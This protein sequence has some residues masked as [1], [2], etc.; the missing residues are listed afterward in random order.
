M[1]FGVA[2]PNFGADSSAAEILDWAQTAE[3]LGFHSVWT[4]EHIIVGP[5]AVDPYGRVYEPLLTLGWLAGQTRRIRLGTSVILVPLHH[6]IYLAKQVATLAELTGGRFI[7]GVGMGWHQD[8]YEFMGV[9]FRGRGARADEAIRL[10]RSLWTGSQKFSGEHWSFAHAT[11]EPVPAQ[12]PEIWVGGP[13]SRAVRRARELGDTWHPT[14]TTSA[15]D[16]ARVRHE[17]PDLRIVPRTDP[18][19]AEAMLTA[20]ADG[21]I[22]NFGSRSDM[23]EFAGTHL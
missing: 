23:G 17:Y 9:E 12:Q 5:E 14:R 7:L 6:P 11:F 19:N 3:D 4:T 21:V 8:E 13:S 15:D 16:V 20:G 1:H 10:M 22:L 18:E 2:L